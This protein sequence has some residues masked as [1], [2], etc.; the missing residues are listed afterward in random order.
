MKHKKFLKFVDFI[1]EEPIEQ[2]FVTVFLLG[3]LVWALSFIEPMFEC[4]EANL[5]ITMCISAFAIK[6]IA[7]DILNA[8]AVHIVLKEMEDK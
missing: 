8:I 1:N 5:F 4:R 2:G 3:L 7:T 6:W